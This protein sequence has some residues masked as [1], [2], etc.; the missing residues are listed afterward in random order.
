[1]LKWLLWRNFWC[2]EKQKNAHIGS[3][4]YCPESN[5][6]CIR[7]AIGKF[8]IAFLVRDN[9]YIFSLSLLLAFTNAPTCAHTHTHTHAHSHSH[10]H[11]HTLTLTHAHP[12]TNTHTCTPTHAHSNSFNSHFH[13]ILLSHLSLSLSLSLILESEYICSKLTLIVPANIC[14]TKFSALKVACEKKSWNRI[15]QMHKR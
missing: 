13:F 15:N 10:T 11:T 5:L 14:S 3:K 9:Y 6:D 4:N 1:M 2:Q 7:C 12:H 8:A